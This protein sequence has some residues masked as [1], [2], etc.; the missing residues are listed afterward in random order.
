MNK[1][2]ILVFIGND[3]CA[4]DKET[5]E[6]IAWGAALKA[7]SDNLF[8]AI[9]GDSPNVSVKKETFENIKT[10]DAIYTATIDGLS[11]YDDTTYADALTKIIKQSAADIVISLA[12][13]IGR[14]LFP[15][16]AATLKTGLTADCTDL[17]IDKSGL[18]KQTRPAYGGN[19]MAE[20]I[21][22][23]KRPQMATVRCG[24]IKPN[25]KREKRYRPKHIQTDTTSISPIKSKLL[26]TE[27]SAASD[28]LTEAKIIVGIG[29]G[30][31]KKENICKI[32][33]FAKA[34]GA[35]T[36]AT[37][38]CVDAGWLPYSKQIGLT[39]TNISPDLYI[40][41]GISGSIQHMTGILNAKKIIAINKDK[42][43]PIFN[44]ADI[45]ITEDIFDILPLLTEQFKK[46]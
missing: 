18:L 39:G 46:L 32:E 24:H 13:D 7:K 35:K 44:Y 4:K 3:Y 10:V 38:A 5:E 30:I 19:I 20:I 42:N 6:I 12:T 41:C 14:S 29:K 9:V 1:N 43:A 23:N 37:R 26:K 40:A 31:R 28:S 17:K 8:L 21:C 34:I 33:E 22:R 11:Y 16:V 2:N 25:L 27:K 36:G 45:G 15:R